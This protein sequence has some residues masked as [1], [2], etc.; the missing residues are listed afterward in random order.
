MTNSQA[1]L[2]AL[3][4]LAMSAFVPGCKVLRHDLATILG[5]LPDDV[6]RLIKSYQTAAL[7][8]DNSIVTAVDN[9]ILTDSTWSTWVKIFLQ[10]GSDIIKLCRPITCWEFTESN[11]PERNG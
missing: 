6:P 2:R 1:I 3:P 11:L 9:R 4:V 10:E 7:S 8:G 5:D